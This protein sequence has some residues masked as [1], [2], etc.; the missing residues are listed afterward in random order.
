MNLKQ[1]IYALIGLALPWIVMIG[2][3]VGH[4]YNVWIY[5]GS[6]TWFLTSV[7]IMLALYE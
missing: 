1:L 5:V 7:S 3:A 2:G 6:I 4:I